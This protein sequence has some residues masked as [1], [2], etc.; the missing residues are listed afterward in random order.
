MEQDKF[1]SKYAKL[2]FL[3]S[4]LVVGIHTST[5]Y[6]YNLDQSNAF[7]RLTVY[8][9]RYI[10]DYVAVVAVPCFF[11]LAGALMF[12]N[13][14][15]ANMKDKMKKRFFS[16]GL[17]YLFWNLIAFLF[18]WLLFS[19]PVFSKYISMRE[20]TIPG[21]IF[22]FIYNIVFYKYN[23]F[24]WFVFVLIIYI[25]ITP[26]FY[27][28]LKYRPFAII[29]LVVITIVMPYLGV[30]PSYLPYYFLGAFLGK[31]FFGFIEG[32]KT[33]IQRGICGLLL[34]ILTCGS[35]ITENK[36][37]DQAV[38]KTIYLMLLAISFWIALDFLRESGSK[39]WT[40]TSF[41]IYSSQVIVSSSVCKLLYVMLPKSW[42]FAL[43]NF[44][45]TLILSAFIC[46]IT[47]LILNKRVKFL[48][49]IM[50]GFRKLK[51]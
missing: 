10:Q 50:N 32:D 30:Y 20:F 7:N 49:N 43:I 26:V 22:E 4:L 8:C 11:I 6:F 17:P 40:N 44:F 45:G 3:L 15:R 21:N 42:F 38:V 41:V 24:L 1:F 23:Y 37:L 47:S 39:W 33:K 2:S 5:I 48:Y 14:N 31:Y 19:L 35:M 36:F 18:D 27:V 51:D 16:L 12:R 28:L 34:I 29:G 25:I 9:I 13:L 46:A